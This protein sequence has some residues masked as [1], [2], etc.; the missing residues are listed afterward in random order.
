M[1][2]GRQCPGDMLLV[3][4]PSWLI[5]DKSK[6]KEGLH[7]LY[8][9]KA[10]TFDRGGNSYI[11]VFETPRQCTYFVNYFTRSC[12]D[13]QRNDGEDIELDLDCPMS[14]SIEL[15]KRVDDKLLTRIWMAEAG[16]FYPET[17]AVIYKPAYQYAV[18]NDASVRII[19][20]ENKDDVRDNISDELQ[21]FLKS[22]GIQLAGKVR[23]V[24]A[25]LSIVYQRIMRHLYFCQ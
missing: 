24:L 25:Q 22:D 1:E 13:G 16:V 20:V 5:K 6:N 15:C 19:A 8:V 21:H 7:S 17:L 2:G 4:S 14:S 18:P 11:D 9:K 10:I 23:I 12:T 3:M